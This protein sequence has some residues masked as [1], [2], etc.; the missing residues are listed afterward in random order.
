MDLN[1][2]QADKQRSCLEIQRFYYDPHFLVILK[3][4]INISSFFIF[5]EVHF[6]IKNILLT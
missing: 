3:N 5:K 4:W 6:A 2:T 1:Y